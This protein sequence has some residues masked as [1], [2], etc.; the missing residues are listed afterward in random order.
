MEDTYIKFE[1]TDNIFSKLFKL[2]HIFFTICANKI[3]TILKC[4]NLFSSRKEI[5]F[6]LEKCS[7][8]SSQYVSFNNTI[9][10]F[11]KKKY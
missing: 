8:Y 3:N 4:S 1:F 7:C 10:E 5:L 9:T 11:I 6:A 2:I